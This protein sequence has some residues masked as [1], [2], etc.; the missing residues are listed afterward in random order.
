MTRELLIRSICAQ[1]LNDVP[2]LQA[3]VS[4]KLDEV[5]SLDGRYISSASEGGRSTSFQVPANMSPEEIHNLLARAL[6]ILQVYTTAQIQN[7]LK[8]PPSTEIR[9]RYGRFWL[10][11]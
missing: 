10:G 7:W 9:P 11:F 4:A 5:L 3:L 1:F 8:T 6:I 2:G